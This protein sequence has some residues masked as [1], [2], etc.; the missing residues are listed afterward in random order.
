LAKK[1]GV[2][3]NPSGISENKEKYRADVNKVINN[4]AFAQQQQPLVKEKE[5]GV[6]R[7]WLANR[8]KEKLQRAFI[9]SLHSHK[10]IILYRNII[11]ESESAVQEEIS[12]V[13]GNH[14]IHMCYIYGGFIPT[15]FQKIEIFTLDKFTKWIMQ[16]K[17]KEFLLQCMDNLDQK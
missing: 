9:L 15:T 6:V 17:N 7:L 12:Y 5:N 3:L 1:R 8:L 11:E 10:P 14:I 16:G 13:V 4:A 2:T